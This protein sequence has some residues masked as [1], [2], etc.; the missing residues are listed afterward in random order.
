MGS[1]FAFM[2][3]KYDT[4]MVITADTQV[5]NNADNAI[6]DAHYRLL[7][8]MS[9]KA[10]PEDPELQAELSKRSKAITLPL[11]IGKKTT[12]LASSISGVIYEFEENLFGF[13]WMRVDIGE[14]V[15]TLTYE[16]RTG[17]HA[18]KLHMGKYGPLL[19]PDK[20]SGKR[21]CT[22]DTNYRCVSAG[23]WE[24]EKQPFRHD[25]CGR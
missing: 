22:R 18:L 13:K 14:D 17:V 2:M 21:I 16:K 15:C 6:R 25:L 11:P 24:R 12:A 9:E 10:L 5:I 7:E 1:Q 23:S 4:V 3:P 20:Y 8:K 19:F